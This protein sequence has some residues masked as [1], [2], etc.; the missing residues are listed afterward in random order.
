MKKIDKIKHFPTTKPLRQSKQHEE[1]VERS[2][3]TISSTRRSCLPAW[4]Y[5]VRNCANIPPSC[6][7]S[8]T[9]V[10]QYLSQEYL[11][12][13]ALC[14]GRIRKIQ[15]GVAG[16]LAHLPALYIDLFFF[17]SFFWEFYENNTKFQR[18][19]AKKGWPWPPRPTTKSAL[20]C[21]FFP[22]SFRRLLCRLL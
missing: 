4:T 11:S 2:L 1:E 7:P 3:W 13:L 14:H 21:P 9:K 5:K 15:K 19:R 12:S 6:H 20:V 17:F 16:T 8:H 22:Y 10:W 18:N